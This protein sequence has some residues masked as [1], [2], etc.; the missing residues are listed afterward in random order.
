MRKQLIQKYISVAAILVFAGCA[1]KSSVFLENVKPDS[2]FN[3]RSVKVDVHSRCPAGNIHFSD[4]EL[5]DLFFTDVKKYLCQSKVCV[6]EPSSDDIVID[7]TIS[8][9]RIMNGDGVAGYCGGYAYA[10][11]DYIYN[12]SKNGVVFHSVDKYN[13]AAARGVTGNFKRISASLSGRGGKDDEKDDIDHMTRML[14]ANIIKGESLG[15]RPKPFK[16]LISP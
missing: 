3:M 8:Y 15:L 10:E 14:A 7:I 16:T 1:I 5:Q 9:R 11:M 13:I 12:L 4:A 2:K 6:E